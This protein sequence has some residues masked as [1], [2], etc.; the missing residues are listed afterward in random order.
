MKTEC[1]VLLGLIACV[2]AGDKAPVKE[3]S[4]GGPA[5]HA[6]HGGYGGVRYGYHGKYPGKCGNDGFYLNDA[7]S[8][9]ICSN[10]NAYVQPCAP[11]TRNNPT[12]YSYGSYYTQNDFC[13]ENL[14]DHGY[15]AAAHAGY[16][17]Y[18]GGYNGGYYGYPYGFYGFG[19][20]HGGYPYY[21]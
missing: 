5:P 16:R 20:G 8:F 14:N 10:G 15:G 3:D 2:F 21:W 17:G 18:N 13:N 4:Y 7:A 11:G 19:Y 12:K 1:V 6:P 9:V